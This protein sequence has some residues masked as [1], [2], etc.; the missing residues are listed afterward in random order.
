MWRNLIAACRGATPRAARTEGRLF[1][2]SGHPGTEHV[3]SFVRPR[4]A[5]PACAR[6][7]LC[8]SLHWPSCPRPLSSSSRLFYPLGPSPLRSPLPTPFQVVLQS[9]PFSHR[10]QH[11]SLPLLYPTLP[12]SSPFCLRFSSPSSIGLLFS[13]SLPFFPLSPLPLPLPSLQTGI[14]SCAPVPV[15]RGAR[16]RLQAAGRRGQHGS[17]RSS[18]QQESPRLPPPRLLRD[19][20][21]KIRPDFP[22][23]CSS[24]IC[25]VLNS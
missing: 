25:N 23:D 2:P 7:G 21:H 18:A 12:V 20:R 10:S 3:D 17:S 9:L 16:G 1:V 19:H 13:P 15:R 14:W 24:E 22:A 11:F 8:R 6:S 5:L 4:G